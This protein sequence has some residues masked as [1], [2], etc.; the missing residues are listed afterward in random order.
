[1]SL[2]PVAG[3]LWYVW[4]SV[5]ARHTDM[6]FKFLIF[7]IAAAF[8]LLSL[9]PLLHAAGKPEDEL[10]GTIK[11][12]FNKNFVTDWAGLEAL[13]GVKWAPLPPASLQNCL[14]DGGCFARQGAAAIGGRRLVAIATGARTIVSNVYLRNVTA[15]FGEE[16]V[17]GA[18]K[19]EGLSAELARCPVKAGVGGTNWYRLK[20]ASTNPG[21]VSI[22][23][24]CNG[25]PCEG[26][27]LTQG[28]DLPPLQPNQLR[29]YT[30][31]CSATG[32]DRQPVSTLMPH[33]QLARTLVALLPPAAGPALY[34]WKALAGLAPE[35]QWNPGG[36]KKGDYSALGDPNPWNTSGQANFSGRQFSLLATGSPADVKTIH[37]DENGMHPRG[38]N[39][40]ASVYA[41]GFAVQLARCGPV[42]TTSTNNWYSVTSAK[43]KP[44]MLRQSIRYDGN[45]V[46]DTYELRLD[47]SLP[48]R[49]PR[50]RDR[51]V[52]GCR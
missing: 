27:V 6:R 32:A 41:Q 51:G 1:L 8:A 29:L 21:Y 23:S 11:A 2:L 20:S 37:F 24:S 12:F 4:I 28:A 10:A 13:P 19:E 42:Y 15:P 43:T 3:T 35:I 22:Q 7:A 33:E 26:F 46:Q 31:Q 25:R 16:A 48:A 49:D 34:D 50:D 9:E 18:L 36:P 30:E 39:L 47:A 17:V 14:A 40:L 38:E 52:G 44:A 45:R 5:S